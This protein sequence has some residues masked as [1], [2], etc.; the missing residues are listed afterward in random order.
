MRTQCKGSWYVPQLLPKGKG[1]RK[2]KEEEGIFIDP[3]QRLEQLFFWFPV[4]I[5]VAMIERIPAHYPLMKPL[6]YSNTIRVYYHW[7]PLPSWVCA[8]IILIGCF[9]FLWFVDLEKLEMLERS[10]GKKVYA[11]GEK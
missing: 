9:L 6:E 4:A 2:K 1:C 8:W 5:I 10:R 3:I 11:T 7:A